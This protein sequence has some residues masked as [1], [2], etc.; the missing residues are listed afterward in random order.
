M[1]EDEHGRALLIPLLRA[2]GNMAAGGG[3]DALVSLQL[4]RSCCAATAATTPVVVI[5]SRE[6]QFA[7]TT[8]HQL[9]PW[10]LPPDSSPQA[11]LL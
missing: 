10:C 9:H 4:L 5:L 6:L 3:R 2:L 11:A 7:A 1:Q 8:S